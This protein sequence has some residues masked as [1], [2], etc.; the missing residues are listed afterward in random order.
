MDT[1]QRGV[2]GV[3]IAAKKHATRHAA[4]VGQGVCEE[5]VS[6]VAGVQLGSRYSS[7]RPQLLVEPE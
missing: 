1:L 7:L 3:L 2:E 6:R 4:A 5:A